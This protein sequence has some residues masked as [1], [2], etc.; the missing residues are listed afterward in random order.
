MEHFERLFAHL[1]QLDPPPTI[2]L[3]GGEP[4]VRDDL[5]DIIR[6]ARTH[7][8][9]VRILTNGIRLADMEYA[10]KIAGTRAHLLFSYDGD[11][12]EMYKVLR[13]RTDVLEKKLKGI[14]NLS[15]IPRARVSIVSCLAFGLNDD[16][17]PDLF[18][19]YHKH[20]RFL[21]GVYLM[22]LTHT[23]SKEEFAYTPQRITTEDLENLVEKT[24]PGHKV[25]FLPLGFVSAF[26]GAM[27]HIGK[28]AMPW[29]GA[30][31]N[32]ES[33]YLLVSNKAGYVPIQHYLK[34]SFPQFAREMHELNGHLNARTE[35]WE[36][37]LTGRVLGAVWL[38]RPILRLLAGR[39]VLK[40]V[41]AH[42]RIGDLFKGKGIGKAWN[43]AMVALKLPFSHKRRK[44]QAMVDRHMTVDG[45][46]KIIILP[47]EDDEIVE[48]DRL[49]RCPSC[50]PY[51]DP[52]TDEIRY[53][54]V[55]SWRMFNKQ[56]LHQL[57]VHYA[58]KAETAADPVLSRPLPDV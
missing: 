2:A 51:F 18:K 4:T 44:W 39:D 21:R 54:P 15:N 29:A 45:V 9:K 49:S 11:D 31:P 20:R 33:F 57:S 37:S 52:E 23:W 5:P 12:P 50:H 55:C 17:L 7:G 26:T 6:L 13:G 22:P 24:F 8:F 48:T 41:R 36:R 53:V 27:A 1:A 34:T 25:E 16:H 14:E 35:R 46:L 58:R 3:F 10:R 47:L 43:I 30:H 28:D 38:R 19:F 40:M 32:C 56:I 42:M